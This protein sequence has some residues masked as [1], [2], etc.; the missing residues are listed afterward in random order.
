MECQYRVFQDY[1]RIL[2]SGDKLARGSKSFGRTGI[3]ILG[4]DCSWK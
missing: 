2:P 4:E 1:Y 3:V